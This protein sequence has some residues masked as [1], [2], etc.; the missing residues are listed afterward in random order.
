VARDG[1][2][3]RVR[4]DR[5]SN[6]NPEKQYQLQP[7]GGYLAKFQSFNGYRLPTQ[8][9]AGNHFGTDY[10]F[11]FFVADVTEVVFPS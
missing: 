5:R 3:T 8:V 2:P 7:F 9:E 4:F 6:A 1:Q 10:Y 11:P